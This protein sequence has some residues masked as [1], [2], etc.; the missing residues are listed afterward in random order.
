MAD[1]LA[2]LEADA[3]DLLLVS[4]DRSLYF[5]HGC[6]KAGPVAL[7]ALG[8]GFSP[9]ASEV[10]VVPYSPES[11][12]RAVALYGAEPVRFV[13]PA[14]DFRMT[15]S[16]APWYA[17]TVT[18]LF[19]LQEAGSEPDAYIVVRWPDDRKQQ[20]RVGEVIEYAG[21]RSAVV[22]V[23]PVLLKRCQL[24]RMSFEIP[25]W[26]GTMLRLLAAG[27]AEPKW[28]E[29][30]GTLK[31]LHLPRL[32]GKLSGY[33]EKRLGP[34]TAAQLRFEQLAPD[35]MRVRLGSETWEA[36]DRVVT[37]A[38]FGTVSAATD[39]LPAGPLGEALAR[40]WPLPRLLYGLNY[41]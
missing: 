11:V 18:E 7:F 22:A 1:C 6:T 39:G 29:A 13:R 38:V 40:L 21:R 19:F 26:D 35:R 14:A 5:R 3:A 17:N 2:Q 31:V 28:T 10:A 12:D 33:V 16:A 20:D 24:A 30:G 9:A 23:V 37:Q 36:E 32:M 4:G 27:G 8:P 15:L 34:T 25:A 41:T